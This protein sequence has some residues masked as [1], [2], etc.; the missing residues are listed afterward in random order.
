MKNQ[1]LITFFV[2]FSLISYSQI[3]LEGSFDDRYYVGTTSLTGYGDKVVLWDL[4]INNKLYL[5]NDDLSLF[6]EISIPEAYQGSPVLVESISNNLFNN[7]DKIEYLI[8]ETDKG[9][10]YC[11]LLNEDGDL[12]NSFDGHGRIFS[13]NNKFKLLIYIDTYDYIYS[14]PGTLENPVVE[15]E[16]SQQSPYPNPSDSRIYLPINDN[17]TNACKVIIYNS[18]GQIVEELNQLSGNDVYYST[19]QLKSG[20]Y[21]YKIFA[22][23]SIQSEGKFIVR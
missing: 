18:A 13:V 1:F 15:K 10:N 23:K 20:I 2:I 19:S 17:N 9:N 5:Y 6:K 3:E 11:Y 7:D 21:L 4:A 12:I 8:N 22:D 14:L 16:F